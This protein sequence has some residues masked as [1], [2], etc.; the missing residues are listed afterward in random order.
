M[1]IL[2]FRYVTRLLILL[3]V[4]M[5]YKL[6][7]ATYVFSQKKISLKLNEYNDDDNLTSQFSKSQADAANP[8]NWYLKSQQS[9]AI[10]RINF[11]PIFLS[12]FTSKQLSILD[13]GGGFGLTYTACKYLNKLKINLTV[14]ELEDIV[15]LLRY[16]EKNNVEFVTD[17]PTG[18]FDIIYF[19]S[20]LQYFDDYKLM[21]KKVLKS[22]PEYIIIA[23]TTY[24]ESSSFKVLQTNLPHSTIHR[25]IFSELDISACLSP[26]VLIHQSSNYAPMHNFKSRKFRGIT[27]AHKNFIYK[28]GGEGEDI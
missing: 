9:Y 25:W 5:L 26:Y 28:R 23:D 16:N 20:S 7:P 22:N 19:G 12:S 15:N 11:L 17:Y 6:I 4:K 27:T 3:C 1:R 14:L 8:E 13:I 21:L 18:E 10:Q 2:R 24:S